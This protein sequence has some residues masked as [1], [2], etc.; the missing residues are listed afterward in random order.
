LLLRAAK[1]TGKLF[2]QIIL[3]APDVDADTF[4]QLCKAY[5][6]V[7][8]RTT[9]YVSSR[10]KAVEAARW[11]HDFARAGLLPPIMVAP[12][13]DTVNVTNADITLLGHG[14]VA[15]A[16]GVLSDMHSLLRFGAPAK[17]FGLQKQTSGDGKTYWLI[18]K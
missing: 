6:R 15:E 10:D 12:G 11:L 16:R 9:L 14:Y 5:A 1:R 13:I 17:R 2:D 3:A 18:G 7:S 8:R 4:R